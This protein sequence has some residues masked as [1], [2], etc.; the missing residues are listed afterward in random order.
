MIP[1]PFDA[2]RRASATCGT[3]EQ[4][5]TVVIGSG[6]S[7]L[8]VASELSRRGVESIVVE[9]LEC[10]DSGTMR[11]V[12]ADAASL[13]ERTELMRLLRGY[14][15]AHCLD[16]R[17]STVA[18]QL[19]IIGHPALITARLGRKQWAVHTAEGV[20]LADHVVLTKYPQNELRRFLRAMGV[21][22]GKD[23]RTTLR[24]I[25][26]HLIGVGEPLTPTT[27]EIVRQ[28]KLVSD[29][30]ATEVPATTQRPAPTAAGITPL[31][32]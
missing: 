8:A 2:A 1:L 14:A 4:T 19:S 6:L 5:S 12:M 32:A 26:L 3:A 7:G 30:I 17:Q 28:A 20:L 21:A 29:T 18:E 16:V 9:A 23:L 22:V 31:S 24:T 10:S 25:G 11:T 13:A 15:S 27:R